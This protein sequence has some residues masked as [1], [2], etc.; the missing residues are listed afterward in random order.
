MPC[1]VWPTFTNNHDRSK[2]IESYDQTIM[3]QEQDPI[4]M[5]TDRE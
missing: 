1:V 3:C 2:M 4:L 5:L